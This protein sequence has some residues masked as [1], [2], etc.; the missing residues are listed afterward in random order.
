MNIIAKAAAFAFKKHEGQIRE[1]NNRPY[2]LHPIQTATIISYLYPRDENLIAAAWLHD[3][4]EDCGVPIETIV[5]LFNVDI[6]NLVLEVTKVKPDKYTAAYF[7]KLKTTRGIILKFADRLSNLSD[8]DGWTDEKIQWY[9]NTSK[10]W[11]ATIDDDI[12]KRFKKPLTKEV[13]KNDNAGSK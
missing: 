1:N 8:M 3:V 10:F 13:I 11:R 7:P 4:V 2:I 9:L 5:R 12:H 6:T